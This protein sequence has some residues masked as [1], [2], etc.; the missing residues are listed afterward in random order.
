MQSRHAIGTLLMAVGLCVS[1]TVASAQAP[2]SEARASFQEGVQNFGARRFAE[3]LVAFQRAYRVRPH[4]SVMVNIANCYL[5]LEQPLEAISWFERYLHDAAQ[6]SPEQ[7]AQIEQ[8]IAEARQRLSSLTILALPAGSE[9]YL[10]GSAVGTAPLR[11]PRA[12]AAGP[13]VLEA[14]GPDGGSVQFQARLE[15]GR[16]L[17]VTLNTTTHESYIGSA[18]PGA[19]DAAMAALAPPPRPSMMPPITQVAA[20]AV[21]PPAVVPPA[22]VPP[23]VVPPAVAAP[24]VAAPAVI[25]PA[26]LA[27]RVDA[28]PTRR[29]A[30]F[31]PAVVTGSVVTLAGVG[32]A[33]GISLYNTRWIAEYND[34]VATFDFYRTRDAETA[35]TYQAQGREH[36][37]VI[38]QNQTLATVSAVVG[39]VG[40]AFTLSA[41]IFWPRE[42]IARGVA[43]VHILPTP[44]GL[45]V[46]G[47]F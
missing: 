37:R 11:G 44:N 9:I 21:V 13:H 28:T 36:L 6:V 10:D 19:N 27:P 40:A 12:V 18:P 7:R 16:A 39:G 35:R 34:I 31:V 23:A 15:P 47:A 5:A 1:P 30:G 2:S 38:E 4:P 17:T 22:V 33:V 46:G 45:A 42:R 8:T 3:A 32:L 29:R 14:R 24:A 41:L 43:T 25:A 26:V 20:P